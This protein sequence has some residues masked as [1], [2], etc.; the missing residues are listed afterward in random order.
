MNSDPSD[1]NKERPKHHFQFDRDFVLNDEAGIYKPEPE[2]STTD[3]Q[4]KSHTVNIVSHVPVDIKRDVL[5]LLFTIFGVAISA[6][7]LIIV[8]QYT[9]YSRGQWHEMI[10]TAKANQES[11]DATTDQTK[12]LRQQLVGSQ[13]AVIEAKF[14]LPQADMREFEVKIRNTGHVIASDIHIAFEVFQANL[15]DEGIVRH[16]YQR[17]IIIPK[18]SPSN[19][20]D[21]HSYPINPP[22]NLIELVK[23]M[24]G[25][26]LIKGTMSYDNGFPEHLGDRQTDPPFCFAYFNFYWDNGKSTG[27]PD[28][29]LRCS[30]VPRAIADWSESQ[31]RNDAARQKEKK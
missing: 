24:N 16:L 13:A 5:A 10:R 19:D 15:P 8:G 30:D 25:A 27:T 26:V 6:F 20:W 23:T 14:Q 7:T 9:Y 3:G 2:K 18:L 22:A 12:L 4:K 11:A 1:K 28:S 31:R 29:L 21:N 17:E